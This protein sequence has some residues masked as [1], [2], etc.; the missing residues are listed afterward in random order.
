M[1]WQVKV[2]KQK[3]VLWKTELTRGSLEMFPRGKQNR[4]IDIEFVLDQAQKHLT[5]LHQKCDH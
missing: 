5:L 1:F 3:I 4:K 2:F